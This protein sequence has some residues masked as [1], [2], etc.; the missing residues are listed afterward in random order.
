MALDQVPRQCSQPDLGPPQV[1][2][3]SDRPLQ[4]GSSA[5]IVPRTSVC[6]S[7][8]PCEKLSRN[9]STP[10]ST[11]FRKMAGSFEAGPDRRHDPRADPARRLDMCNRH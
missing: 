3:N 9:R 2:E 11:S 8:V 1:L 6:S 10:A 4:L 7:C 5:R